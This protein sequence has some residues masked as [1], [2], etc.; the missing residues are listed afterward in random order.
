LDSY[1]NFQSHFQ[2]ASCRVN[3]SNGCLKTEYSQIECT[4]SGVSVSI[5]LYLSTK[6]PYIYREV[7][8]KWTWQTG[9]NEKVMLGTEHMYAVNK[10]WLFSL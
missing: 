3:A 7:R 8:I 10:Y 4:P 1:N 9:A 2:Q 6:H 5:S